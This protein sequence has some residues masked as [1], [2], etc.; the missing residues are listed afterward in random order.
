MAK[1]DRVVIDSS[2]FLGSPLTRDMSMFLRGVYV[3]LCFY[4]DND[5][6]VDMNDLRSSFD[7]LYGHVP[8]LIGGIDE[9][10]DRG[11][12]IREGG[13]IRLTYTNGAN[14]DD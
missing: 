4:A 13:R 11:L 7:S 6:F 12:L 14:K 1:R 9:L 10:V 8:I 3:T 5:G 2:V